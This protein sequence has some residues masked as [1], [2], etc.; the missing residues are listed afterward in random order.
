MKYA[1]VGEMSSFYGSQLASGAVDAV[2]VFASG[3][4]ATFGD[5]HDLVECIPRS[6]RQSASSIMGPKGQ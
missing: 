5:L 6:I 3:K 4:V 2:R 1:S